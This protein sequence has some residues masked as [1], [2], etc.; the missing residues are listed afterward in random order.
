[1]DPDRIPTVPG[2]EYMR[3]QGAEYRAQ[4][5]TMHGVGYYHGY[6]IRRVKRR[7]LYSTLRRMTAVLDVRPGLLRW[8]CSSRRTRRILHEGTMD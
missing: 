7:I 1:M 5:R 6:R 4:K 3:A 2:L 8:S